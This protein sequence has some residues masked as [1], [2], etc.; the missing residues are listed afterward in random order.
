MFHVAVPS[1]SY[2]KML[3]LWPWTYYM[4]TM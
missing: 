3:V 2:L 4:T 1:E